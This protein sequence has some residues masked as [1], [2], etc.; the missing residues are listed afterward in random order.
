VTYEWRVGATS[1]LRVP[2][3]IKIWVM[4]DFRLKTISTELAN[5]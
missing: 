1:N 3:P 5:N 4:S 2:D